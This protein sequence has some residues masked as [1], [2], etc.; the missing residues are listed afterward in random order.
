MEMQWL[1]SFDVEVTPRREV[2][3]LGFTGLNGVGFSV[4]EGGGTWTIYWWHC[5]LPSLGGNNGRVS[6]SL[7]G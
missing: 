4:L 5:S 1:T 7:K 6:S 3:S 2:A